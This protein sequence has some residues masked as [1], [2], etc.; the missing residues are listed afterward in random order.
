MNDPAGC[1]ATAYARNVVEGR[2]VAGE[3]IRLACQRHIDDLEHGTERGLWFDHDEARRRVGF[4]PLL[5]HSKGKWAGKTFELQQYQQWMTGCIFGWKR[6]D[7]HRRFRVAHVEMARKNGKTQWASGM[8]NCVLVMD[9]EGGAEIYNVAGK[10]DQAKLTHDESKRMV[11]SSPALSKRLS[12]FKNAICDESTNSKYLPLGA[13][14]DT[15]DGLNIHMAI[16]D[17]LHAWR[18]RSLWDVIETATGARE[19]PLIVITTTAGYDKHSIWWER[20]EYA[21]AVLKGVVPDDSLFAAIFTLDDKD[22]WTDESTWVKANPSLGVTVKLADLRK[23]CEEAKAV[24]G[25]Q[26]AFRRLKLN[27]PT[28]QADR[29]LDV[30]TW[31]VCAGAA[32]DEDELAGRECFGGLDLSATLDLTALVWLFPPEDEEGAW[33]VLWRFWL[34]G[35]GIAERAR[36]DAVPY[37]L[38]ASQGHLELVPGNTIEYD[39]VEAQVLKDAERFQVRELA[40]DRYFANQLTLSLQDEGVNVVGYGQGFASM[41]APT[42]ELEKLVVSGTLAH[43][44]HPVARWNASNVAVKQDPAGNLKPDKSRS[45]G[46]IDGIVAL[47]M[48]LGRAMVARQAGPLAVEV[49]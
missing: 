44:G 40:F 20:R 4:F 21:I 10:F 37:D 11:K 42:K 31:D 38:W 24:P 13:D 33:R 23:E 12:V 36:R 41:A 9:R 34:P 2:I 19:Q 48:A 7:R 47:C 27:M 3:L 39:L 26:N 29:W 18:R 28:E 8:G 30:A 1:P 6:R 22:E 32:F 49:W 25:K 14:S 16:C 43:G 45:T 5:K 35:D 15:L 17:E 46:R